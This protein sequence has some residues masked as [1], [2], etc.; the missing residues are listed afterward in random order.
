M[1]SEVPEAIKKLA[2]NRR[3]LRLGRHT[4]SWLKLTSE[5]RKTLYAAAKERGRLYRYE[6]SGIASYGASRTDAAAML[7]ET[8]REKA[9]LLLRREF[10]SSA[11]FWVNPRQLKI[12]RIDFYWRKARLGLTIT[13]PLIDDPYRGDPKR[14]RDSRP[15]LERELDS[16]IPENM[17]RLAIIKIPYYMVWHQPSDVINRINKRL[18]ASGQY[19]RLREM[20]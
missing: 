17:Q 18:V 7:L 8:T 20:S 13:G 4:I 16:L 6:F 5:E 10:G 1:K 3:V 2:A 12:L 14:T 15:E 19:G 9:F 11:R